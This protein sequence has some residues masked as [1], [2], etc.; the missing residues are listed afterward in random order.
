MVRLLFI[1]NGQRYVFFLKT[2]L[3]ISEILISLGSRSL[4]FCFM[5]LLM[6]NEDVLS[7]SFL[8]IIRWNCVVSRF[9]VVSLPDKMH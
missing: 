7:W 4:L 5:M 2:K 6:G 1:R 9:F 8:Y 3:N